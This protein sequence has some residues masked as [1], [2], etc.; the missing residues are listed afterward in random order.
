MKKKLFLLALIIFS[1]GLANAQLKMLSSGNVGV[2]MDNPTHRLQVYG[3]FHVDSYS[4]NWGRALWT[5]VHFNSACAYH[6]YN[7]VYNR[8]VFFV[9]GEGWLWTMKG[10]FFGSDSVMKKNITPL[11]SSLSTIKKLNGVKYQYKDP[12]VEN[13][14]S[15]SQSVVST[16]KLDEYRLGLV[17][18][19]V[20]KIIP[21]VVKTMPDN[22]KAIAY[23]DLIALL[24]EGIKEQQNQLETLQTIVYS[25]EKEILQLKNSVAT[26][27]KKNDNK[28]KSR[29]SSLNNEDIT[30]SDTI[31]IK[32]KLY[33]NI[34]N[35]FSL[36]TTIKFEIPSNSTSS[37]L[38]INDL[39][40]IELKSFI[41][42][43]K[44][45]GSIL[46]NGSE[47]KAGMYLYTL[48]VDNKI[49][50]TKRMILTKE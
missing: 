28:S 4:P 24:I 47:F 12:S 34:P 2:G 48:L 38:I 19:E 14:F 3:D 27:C 7:T 21:E 23:T 13:S 44:G 49:I 32:A 30:F 37:V 22:T 18:Q 36:N 10:G 6:L 35:P 15:K 43:Q 11:T 33:D 9:C 8:D 45:P 42:S 41:I 17:A 40:G 29:I 50:D 39:Q 31:S 5:K 16:T 25:H 46:I 20:E 1:T 26:C